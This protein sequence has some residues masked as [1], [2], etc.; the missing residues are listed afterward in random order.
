MNWRYD[1]EA[2]A[3]YL[4]LSPEPVVESEEVRP[5]LVLDFDAAGHIVGIEVLSA[6]AM[7]PAATLSFG[8]AA[9]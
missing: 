5:S 1:P 2:D 7:L 4:R 8:I 3:A 9:E 6:R